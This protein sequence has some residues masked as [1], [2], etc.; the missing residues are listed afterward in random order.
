MA[1]TS[2]MS[3]LR[4]LGGPYID[5]CHCFQCPL[6]TSVDFRLFTILVYKPPS[7]KTKPALL[8]GLLHVGENNFAETF[9]RWR[10]KVP[11]VYRHFR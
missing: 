9:G 6:Q 4:K 10:S 1:K 5:L 7:K 11:G 2:K 3:V 8:E